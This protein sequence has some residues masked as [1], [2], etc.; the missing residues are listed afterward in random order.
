MKNV[1]LFSILILVTLSSC[2]SVSGPVDF[3][4]EDHFQDGIE[5]YE[6]GEFQK[7]EEAFLLAREKAPKNAEIYSYLGFIALKNDDLSTAARMFDKALSIAAYNVH[8]LTGKGII[9]FKQGK[10]HTSLDFLQEAVT[11]DKKSPETHYWLGVLY[12]SQGNEPYAIE[13]WE[14]T[15]LYDPSHIEAQ[16]E[17]KK[18][19]GRQNAFAEK[20][21]YEELYAAQTISRAQL[22]W[23]IAREF[24]LQQASS[25]RRSS[26]LDIR[27]HWAL[28]E[29]NRIAGAAVMELN[30][31]RFFPDSSTT[32]MM[33]AEILYR[34]Y[35]AMLDDDSLLEMFSGMESPYT[36]VESGDP[37]IGAIIFV[38]T[39]DV[40]EGYF[41]GTFRPHK[42]ASGETVFDAIER[43]KEITG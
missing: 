2:L 8:A 6:N 15:L 29:I 10:I 23:I 11:L 14:Q 30:E 41:D 42:S 38:T 43:L 16:L 26:P 24:D 20:P 34:L 5:F 35:A 28:Q 39:F 40:M 1:T 18:I 37:D 17:L 19:Y 13:H 4:R 25:G 33:L 21:E 32:R 3:D 12:Y 27:N 9:A 31:D 22:A 7:A 36:D